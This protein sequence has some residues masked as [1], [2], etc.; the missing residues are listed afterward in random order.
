MPCKKKADLEGWLMTPVLLIDEQVAFTGYVPDK[1]LIK[2][3]IMNHHM[4]EVDKK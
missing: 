1:E 3:A 2:K 4:K